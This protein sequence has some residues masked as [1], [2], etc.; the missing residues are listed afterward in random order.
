M[1]ASP[2]YTLTGTFS[3]LIG[4][5]TGYIQI[6]L[7]GYSPQ[8]PRI[9]GGVLNTV[10]YQTA[11]GSSFSVTL[12]G[13][14]QIVPGSTFYY[15]SLFDANGRPLQQNVPYLFQGSGTFD[16]SSLTPMVAAPPSIPTPPSTVNQ[17]LFLAGPITGTAAPTYR[18]IAPADLQADI[19]SSAWQVVDGV[20]VQ[21]VQA[22][23]AALPATGGTI[24]MR[25]NSTSTALNLGTFDPG[26]K[27]VTLLLGPYTYQAA[28][29]TVET[30]LRIY[31]AG[32]GSQ[33][34]VTG[35]TVIQSS[36]S[37]KNL[38]VLSQTNQAVQG[39]H[40]KD[41]RVYAPAGGS[42][43]S[44]RGFYIQAQ[45]GLGLWYSR[46]D[47]LMIGAAG[48]GLDHFH[49]GNLVFDA[50][51]NTGFVQFNDFTNVMSWRSANSTSGHSLD[52]WGGCAQNTFRNC[53]FDGPSV[54]D[55]GTNVF[56]GDK[57]NNGQ[58]ALPNTA[59]FLDCTCQFA[60]KGWDVEGS[61]SI[62][63]IGNHIEGLGQVWTFSPGVIN[64]NVSAL[65]EGSYI[66]TSGNQSGAGY[67]LKDTSSA[68]NAS[69]NFLYNMI[70]S[71]PDTYIAGTTANINQIGNVGPGAGS[72]APLNNVLRG[73]LETSGIVK[74]DAGF[75]QISGVTINRSTF[76]NI[77]IAAAGAMFLIRDAANGGSALV[78]ISDVSSVDVVANVGG[79]TSFAATASPTANQIGLQVSSTQLQAKAGSS[80]GLSIN[81][82]QISFN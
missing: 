16:L 78:L 51:V 1:S 43:A 30:N 21:T 22:A 20:E 50:T 7:S 37:T 45:N 47:N 2:A 56:I 8:I 4:S 26:T 42:G 33:A 36:D 55:G 72:N 80:T 32:P 18:V 48:P 39:V 25:F 49:G 24:D 23:L 31:G 19:Y 82:T 62:T 14:D 70:E 15:V 44:Q 9:S 66:A 12:Y 34:S 79:S 11:L 73:S 68:G 3:S 59:L 54:N 76:T 65:I 63:W 58:D 74:A 53:Q 6:R 29:I 64:N 41:F 52:L 77:G 81:F 40:L 46:F 69:I 17:N 57:T 27:S 28:Q 38:F 61:W 67:I 13:N 5:D 71:T 10:F 75:T 35:T 60:S